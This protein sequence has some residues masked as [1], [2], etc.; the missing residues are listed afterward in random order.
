MARLLFQLL[1]LQLVLVASV[2]SLFA[3]KKPHHSVKYQL[4]QNVLT[5]GTS[6]VI[7]NDKDK[8]VYKVVFLFRFQKTFYKIFL[9]GI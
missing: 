7:K 1:A 3:A 6:Y 2:L 9:G 4:Q 8:P 5:L